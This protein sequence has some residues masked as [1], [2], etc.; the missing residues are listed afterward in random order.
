[1]LILVAVKTSSGMYEDCRHTLWPLSETQHPVKS[2]V[3]AVR[4][5]FL[6][7]GGLI[8]VAVVHALAETMESEIIMNEYR[9]CVLT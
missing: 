5:T 9:Y 1:M 7:S 3:G 8:I 6:H 4:M 2:T